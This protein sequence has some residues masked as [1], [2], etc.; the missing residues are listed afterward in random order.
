MH[1]SA[2]MEGTTPS[3]IFPA[4]NDVAP[5]A[6]GGITVFTLDPTLTIELEA[7]SALVEPM[8]FGW[9]WVTSHRHTST[10]L[11]AAILSTLSLEGPFL[12]LPR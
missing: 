4:V 10:L 8:E 1:L 11:P 9:R 3:A 6:L 2:D 12:G 7:I 5:T